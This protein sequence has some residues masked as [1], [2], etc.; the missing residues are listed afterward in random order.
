MRNFEFYIQ[1]LDGRNL[2][3]TG[4]IITYLALFDYYGSR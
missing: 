4:V 2:G 3:I 1:L